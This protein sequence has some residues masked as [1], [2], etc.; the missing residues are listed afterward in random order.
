MDAR[1]NVGLD[2]ETYAMAVRLAERY[3]DAWP[4]QTVRR[5]VWAEA[6]SCGLVQPTTEAMVV[7]DADGIGECAGSHLDKGDE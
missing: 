1:H 4:V 5:L 6:E 2:P 3:R 7:G